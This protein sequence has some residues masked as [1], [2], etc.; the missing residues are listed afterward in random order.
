MVRTGPVDPGTPSG[1]PTWVTGVLTRNWMGSGAMEIP[2]GA[3][4]QDPDSASGSLTLCATTTALKAA[5]PFK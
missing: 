2:P 1:S 3:L 5:P 4:I